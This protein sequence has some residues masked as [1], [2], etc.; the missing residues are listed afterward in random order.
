MLKCSYKL[1]L[2]LLYSNTYVVR[3]SY[4]GTFHLNNILTNK[5]H[6]LPIE[7]N[8]VLQTHRFKTIKLIK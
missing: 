4:P 2:Q 6:T 5:R 7:D 1:A 8:L 3:A